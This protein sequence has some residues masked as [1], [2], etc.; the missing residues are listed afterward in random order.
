[1]KI[2]LGIS[3][4]ADDVFMYHGLR[5]GKVDTGGL[6]IEPVVEVFQTLNDQASRGQLEVT[7]M[8]VHAYAYAHKRYVLSRSGGS[9]G[10]DCGPLLV[11]RE[12]MDGEQLAAATIAVPG[13]TSS[14]Y[15]A[16]TLWGPGIRT[17]VLPYDKIIPA[18]ESGLADCGLISHEE[19]MSL[20]VTG[21]TCVLDFGVWW[22]GETGGMP[23]PMGCV[24]IQ[25]SLPGDVQC[26]LQRII[27]ESVQYGLANR[28]EALA[29]VSEQAGDREIENAAEFIGRYVNELSVDVGDRGLAAM[30][31]FL[32][33]GSTA[34][35]I[36]DVLPLEFP[37]TS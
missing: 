21:L 36:P 13:V 23:L 18:V 22:S 30:E 35:I 7:S 1:M 4:E 24:A 17:R 29:A 19:Q 16:L 8:S 28:G 9:F 3:P 34:G 31:E 26:Q 2:R 10:M 33:R 20:N 14:A 6:E 12:T 27:G 32:S 11:A 5:S 25:R 37:P 15:L